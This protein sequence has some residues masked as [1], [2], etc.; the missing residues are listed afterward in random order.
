M[1][2]ADR[3]KGT[4]WKEWEGKQRGE[5]RQGSGT[6]WREGRNESLRGG[7]RGGR[8]REGEREGRSK[9]GLWIDTFLEG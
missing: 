9:E 4:W 6:R 7:I 2:G 3:K 8:G 5:K 1:G